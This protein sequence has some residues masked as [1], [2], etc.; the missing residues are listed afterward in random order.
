MLPA[1][2]DFR[3]AHSENSCEGRKAQTFSVH[4]QSSELAVFSSNAPKGPGGEQG[5]AEG[6]CLVLV[7]SFP[8]SQHC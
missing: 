3:K 1:H 7:G 5:Q 4:P 2:G 6:G 8:Q